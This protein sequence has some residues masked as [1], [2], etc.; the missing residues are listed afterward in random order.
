[1]E[2]KERLQRIARQKEEEY[3][4]TEQKYRE[5]H[6][7]AER[8]VEQI[9]REFVQA[10]KWELSEIGSIPIWGEP[11]YNSHPY[12]GIYE[13]I[14]RLGFQGGNRSEKIVIFLAMNPGE[15]FLAK[16]PEIDSLL[17]RGVRYS[18]SEF[19]PDP[20]QDE[21]LWMTQPVW[22]EHEQTLS[23]LSV[24]PEALRSSLEAA[25]LAVA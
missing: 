22:A 17:I 10:L 7:K 21:G 6:E 1:M 4:R 5:D 18:F 12:L 9:S 2:W 25:Y 15:F 13:K 20:S 11:G 16:N 8:V 14:F 3:Q 19:D 23:L 24:T